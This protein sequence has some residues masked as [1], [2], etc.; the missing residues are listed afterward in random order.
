[1]KREQVA[2]QNI[3][4]DCRTTI[5]RRA[6]R[7]RDCFYV[8]RS[9][10]EK[11]LT[12]LSI[13]ATERLKDPAERQ[14]LSQQ[15]KDAWARGAIGRSEWH[16]AVKATLAV[17]WEDEGLRQRTGE[18]TRKNWQDPE[19]RRKVGAGVEAFWTKEERAARGILYTGER[20]PNWRGGDPGGYIGF[21]PKVRKA[22]RLRDN[23]R[24]MI[25]SIPENGLAHD[26]HHIDYRP[27]NSDMSNLITLCH[28]CHARTSNGDRLFWQASCEQL[29][30]EHD[31]C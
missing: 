8:A 1:M 13:A 10:N 5:S 7:C 3:C 25:C 6:T 28:S 20:N 18:T 2:G 31:Y 4:I 16:A 9:Q 19:Y 22:V 11:W 21:T 17:R 27:Q 23:H 26:V 15:S 12:S 30:V 29:M 14:R 24:C